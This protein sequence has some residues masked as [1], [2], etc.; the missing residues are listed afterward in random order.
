M[1][2]DT[3]RRALV[4]LAVGIPVSAFFLWLAARDADL[5]AVRR[6]LE[7]AEPADVALAVLALM[8]VYVFQA[9]RW[10]SIA[11]TPQVRLA[12][13]YEM[14]VSGVACNN[15]LPARLGD[16]LR[17]RWLGLAARIPA[18]RG[19]GTVVIDRGCDLA[20]LLLLLAVGLAAVG[21]SD[22]TVRIALGGVTAL[23]ALGAVV[24]FAR[25]YT[26]R[27]ERERRSR[28]LLRRVARDTAEALA[29]P[30]GRR[31]PVLWILLSLAAWTL[32]AIGASA[33]ARSL[34]IELGLL[35]AMFVAAVM[36]LGVAIPSSP[37]FVG[38]YEW[39]GVASLGVLGV[40]AEEALAF[41]ILLHA[42]WYVPTTVGGGV[43]LG[44]RALV[45]VRRL[46]SARAASGAVR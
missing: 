46:R 17:A 12:R 14:V 45:R 31:H 24:V 16:L 7:D 27:R 19:L 13:F 29:E 3:S 25:E 34:G 22:W 28:G 18:G 39:L 15:V 9:A 2:A 20:A 35:D 42:C 8:G 44:A 40:G 30:F 43:A 38:T 4:G 11:R 6:V 26:G 37:G 10:R 41:A 32:W 23:A 5:G 36:N 33:V 1:A 21:T